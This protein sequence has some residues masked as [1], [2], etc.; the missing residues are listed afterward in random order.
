MNKSAN[1][2]P[3]IEDTMTTK[4]KHCGQPESEHCTFE[5]LVIPDGCVCNPGTWLVKIPPVCNEF[6]GRDYGYCETCKHGKKCHKV[7]D[8]EGEP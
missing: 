6:S 3:D 5:A 4:C 2:P 8:I 1:Q 7:Q